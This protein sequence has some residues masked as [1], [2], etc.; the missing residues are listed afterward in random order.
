YLSF[1]L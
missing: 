1:L